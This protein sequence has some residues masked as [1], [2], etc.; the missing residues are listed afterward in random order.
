MRYGS[1]P[2]SPAHSSDRASLCAATDFSKLFSLLDDFV[3]LPVPVASPIRNKFTAV[4]KSDDPKN[5]GPLGQLTDAV[6]DATAV[7]ATLVHLGFQSTWSRTYN[8][9]LTAAKA[10]LAAHPEAER[11]YISGH[12]LGAALATLSMIALRDDLGTSLPFEVIVFGLPRIGNPPFAGLLD[13]LITDP[14][15]N[16][17][18]SHVTNYNDVVPHLGP[19]I[20]GFE[21]PMNEVW[22]PYENSP[23]ANNCPGQEN[24]NCALSQSLNLT[25][26]THAGVST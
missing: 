23:S 20:L 12:S 21:H 5:P 15:Q 2:A 1:E 19:L 11:V 16:I 3:F 13:Q 22:I 10:A 26:D 4:A 14:S 8:A 9:V 6:T 25:I 18:F 17:T 7:S 24:T